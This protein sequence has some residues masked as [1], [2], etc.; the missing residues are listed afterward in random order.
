MI[1]INAFNNVITGTYEEC[2][3]AF[4]KAVGELEKKSWPL[5]GGG[6]QEEW[7]YFSMYDYIDD[8]CVDAG[9]VYPDFEANPLIIEGDLKVV[10]DDWNKASVTLTNPKINDVFRFFANNHDGHHGFLEGVYYNFKDGE[11]HL[12]SGS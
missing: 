10:I 6:C 5:N 4:D 9:V 12:I 1:N 11:L 3:V 2:H 8:D 7:V